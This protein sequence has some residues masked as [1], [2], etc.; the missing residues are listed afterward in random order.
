MIK[1]FIENFKVVGYE[2]DISHY[3]IE[4]SEDQLTITSSSKDGYYNLEYILTP[5]GYTHKTWA[6][7]FDWPTLDK[8]RTLE[9]SGSGIIKIFGGPLS[10]RII[11]YIDQ[12]NI[13]LKFLE[14]F[15]IL[16]LKLPKIK[17]IIKFLTLLFQNRPVFNYGRMSTTLRDTISE[18]QF[19]KSKIWISK[20]QL[21]RIYPLE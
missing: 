8:C 9:N 21:K 3:N 13:V 10:K 12:K 17:G 4:S 14:V 16:C 6:S 2:G 5:S 7:K 15:S 20:L 18:L 1:I 11:T 19:L